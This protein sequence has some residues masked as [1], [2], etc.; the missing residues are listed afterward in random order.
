MGCSRFAAAYFNEGAQL[1]PGPARRPAAANHA[2]KPGAFTHRSLDSIRPLDR[3]RP[4]GAQR[5]RAGDLHRRAAQESTPGAAD[6]SAKPG[7]CLLPPLSLLLT[8][9]VNHQGQYL[10]HRIPTPPHSGAP[11]TNPRHLTGGGTGQRVELRSRART[12]ENPTGTASGT[13][14]NGRELG[15]AGMGT[16]A[17]QQYGHSGQARQERSAKALMHRLIVPDVDRSAKP[18]ADQLQAIEGQA[19]RIG[20]PPGASSRRPI[21]LSHLG[22]GAAPA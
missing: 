12:V 17:A 20:A 15:S 13:L 18:N 1:G 14:G 21:P 5:A 4:R 2:A 10:Q 9:T 8:N 7:R 16:H 6:H 3:R 11:V 22:A 19:R